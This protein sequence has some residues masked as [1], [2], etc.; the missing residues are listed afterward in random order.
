SRPPGPP[1]RR[2]RPTPPAPGRRTDSRQPA[3]STSP[4]LVGARHD[5]SLAARDA[6][7][8]RRQIVEGLEVVHWQEV[9]DVGECDRHAA[10]ARRVAGAP[11]ERIQ[12]DEAMAALSHTPHL[13]IEKRRVA[14]LPTVADQEHHGATLE[15]AAGVQP[16]E[17]PQALADAGAAGEVHDLARGMGERGVDVANLEL[18]RDP[19]EPGAEDEC[20]GAPVA[21]RD[22]VE[23]LE[24]DA[25]VELHRAADVGEDDQRAALELA[26]PAMEYER[27]A[28]VARRV[29]QHAP[30]VEAGAAAR[31]DQAKRLAD[32]QVEP[33]VAQRPRERVELLAGALAEV[34]A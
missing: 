9:V 6:R 19:R 4:L 13:G 2:A 7:E 34:L 3:S 30:H 29:A 24:E 8:M 11:Q 16:I 31:A 1:D 25:G 10:R 26:A 28:A 33:H 27:D 18:A 5:G 15:H 14:G 22:A 12:P 21:V 32:R 23:E 20:L 17:H